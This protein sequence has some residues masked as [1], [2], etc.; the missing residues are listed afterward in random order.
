MSPRRPVRAVVALVNERL[1]TQ[2]RQV[3]RDDLSTGVYVQCLC[4]PRTRPA[5]ECPMEKPSKQI[6]SERTPRMGIQ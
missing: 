1:G 2:G 5:L 3:E 4:A 6:A